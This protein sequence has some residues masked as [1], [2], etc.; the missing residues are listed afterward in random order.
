MGAGS[1]MGS[2]PMGSSSPAG[3]A[4]FKPLTDTSVGDTSANNI[5]ITG[6]SSTWGH[7]THKK[8]DPKHVDYD[9]SSFFHD[10]RSEG[11]RHTPV[12][13]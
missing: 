8:W 6:Q 9:E 11:R 5:G 2:G 4:P 3:T 1:A 7:D 12:G 10:R 13:Y